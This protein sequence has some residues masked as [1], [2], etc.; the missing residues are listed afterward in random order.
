MLSKETI[1]HSNL[2]VNNSKKDYQAWK[3]VSKYDSLQTRQ[4]KPVPFRTG[5]P[6]FLYALFFSPPLI[7]A[8][9]LKG[10]QFML[11]RLD[12]EGFGSFESHTQEI[13]L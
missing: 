5:L 10:L 7:Y 8:R 1:G 13:A 12:K 3:Y 2:S 11:F 4:G 6:C 9:S